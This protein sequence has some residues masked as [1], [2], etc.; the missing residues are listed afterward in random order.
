MSH[1]TESVFKAAAG[2]RLFSGP[3]TRDAQAKYRTE[4]H[5]DRFA[6]SRRVKAALLATS[7]YSQLEA[8]VL[9]LTGPYGGTQAGAKAIAQQLENRKEGQ[10]NPA[11]DQSEDRPPRYVV[12][13]QEGE[14]YGL[15]WYV[16]GPRGTRV[17]IVGTAEQATRWAVLYE[18]NHP[19]YDEDQ[20]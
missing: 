17:S 8:R 19:H 7:D 3:A 18:E 15:G 1:N 20:E 12:V 11:R 6:E 4:Y 9:A 14:G 13:A 5:W 2:P 16:Q 10:Y